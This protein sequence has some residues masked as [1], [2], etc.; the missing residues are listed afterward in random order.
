VVVLD[1][2]LPDLTGWDV[3]RG[4]DRSKRERCRVVVIS[5]GPIS[6]QR[7]EELQPDRHLEKPFPMDALVRIL[8]EL[9][10][11]GRAQ[12]DGRFGEGDVTS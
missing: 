6:A 4:M 1:V 5:A 9:A 7:I 12:R 2:N 8:S 11:A 3:L 10:P